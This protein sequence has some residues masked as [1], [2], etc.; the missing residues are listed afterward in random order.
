MFID[1][2]LYVWNGA[3]GVQFSMQRSLMPLGKVLLQMPD[4]ELQCAVQ[5]RPVQDNNIT[6]ENAPAPS[7]RS[8]LARARFAMAV[9]ACTF[10]RWSASNGS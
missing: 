1:L 10:M 8:P 7:T 4:I 9:V 6:Q 5:V 3:Y 2:Q